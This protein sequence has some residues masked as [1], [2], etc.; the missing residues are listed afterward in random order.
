MNNSGR[1]AY[2][3]Q[4][5]EGETT[6]SITRH[7]TA[8]GLTKREHFAAMAMQGLLASFGEHDVTDAGE[9]ASDAVLFAD[10]LLDKL[11]HSQ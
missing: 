11:E 5:H 2:P 8:D 9:I 10:A 7:G 3:L 1:A 6:D 4:L